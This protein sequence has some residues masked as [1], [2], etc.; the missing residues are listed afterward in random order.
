MI[1]E[2]NR[3]SPCAISQL[4]QTRTR[5]YERAKRMMFQN[6]VTKERSS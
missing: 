2:E 6:D 1:L 4:N 3:Q 5:E